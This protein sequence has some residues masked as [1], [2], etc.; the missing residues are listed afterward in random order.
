MSDS[1]FPQQLADLPLAGEPV[2]VPGFAA[3]SVR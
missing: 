3:G 1:T 2:R